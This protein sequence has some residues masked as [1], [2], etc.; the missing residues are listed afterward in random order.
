MFENL[1]N[2][3][4]ENAGDAIINNTAIPNER[5]DEAISY[6]SNS[7]V[8][9]LREALVN[10]NI[11]DVVSLFKG[12][13]AV[14]SPVAQNIHGGFVQ[15]LMDKFGLDNNQAGGIASNLLPSILNKF[16]SKTNDPND[17]S[18]D[19]GDIIQ[20]LSGGNGVIDIQN[21]ISKFQG[22]GNLGG[23][24]MDRAKEFFN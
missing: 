23:G 16:I 24:L 14:A 10:G 13:N 6:A 17:K 5:N 19:L 21:I 18:F 15:S 4:K 9:G 22:T 7:I 12:G 11:N 20:K 1:L 3:V 2:L 8:D